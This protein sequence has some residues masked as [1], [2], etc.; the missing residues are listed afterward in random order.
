MRLVAKSGGRLGLMCP[1]QYYLNEKHAGIC[2]SITIRL[3]R[4]RKAQMIG[5]Q[6]F[7]GKDLMS[8]ACN[9]VQGR[10][11]RR[12]RFRRSFVSATIHA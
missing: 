9:D 1:P 4:N 8:P 5:Q 12:D 7:T 6:K 3:Q 11:R 2:I 10:F